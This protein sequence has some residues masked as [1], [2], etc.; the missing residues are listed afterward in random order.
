[1]T[2]PRMCTMLTTHPAVVCRY[3]DLRRTCSALCR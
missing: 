1:M 3:V 2:A